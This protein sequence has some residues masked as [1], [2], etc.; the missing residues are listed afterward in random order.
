M[1]EPCSTVFT[2]GHSTHSLKEFVALLQLHELTAVA[3]VRSA[4][5]SRFNPQFNREPFAKAL[6]AAGIRYVY[7]GNVLGGRSEDPACYEDGRIRYDRVAATE[8][9]KDGLVRI[10]HGAAEYRIALMCAEKEPL[11]C[12]RTLLVSRALDQQGVNIAHIHANGRLEPH[13]EAMD[14]LLDFLGLPR[15]DLYATRE[16][17]IAT[18]VARQSELV[19]HVDDKP[20]ARSEE[21]DS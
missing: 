20:V 10:V 4:P 7:L 3:D 8:S 16:E 9:F 12:H 21:Q 6:G 17:L 13:G 19:A 15:E 11:E 2:V 18:A 5:Y 14:R 1:N